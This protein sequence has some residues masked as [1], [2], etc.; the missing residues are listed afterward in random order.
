MKGFFEA[1]RT[2][3]TAGADFVTV[4]LISG[5][6]HIP[7]DPGA[8]MLVTR[9]GLQ[10]GTVGGGKV[11]ARAILHAKSLL[12]ERKSRPETHVW[13]LQKDIGMTC[14]GEVTYLFEPHLQHEWRV[15][16]FGAG[17]VAQSLVRVLRDLPVS[18]TC[19]DARAEW[20]EKLPRDQANLEIFHAALPGEWVVE[21]GIGSDDFFVVITQGHATDVPVLEAI[22]RKHPL[23]RYIGVIGSETK[24]IKIKSELRERGVSEESIGCL[25]IPIGLD[26]GTNHPGEIAISIAAELLQVRDRKA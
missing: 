10:F 23:P 26:I 3:E 21:N 22:F 11:E 7:Q 18:I 12:D 1:A 13:N 9:E 2:L 25:R 19:V 20:V 15:R 6:G 17:H 5:R 14:G 16:I 4:T 8:K 24:G